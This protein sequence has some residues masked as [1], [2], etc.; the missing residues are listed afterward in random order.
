[1]R[2]P[3]WKAVVRVRAQLA[4]AVSVDPALRAVWLVGRWCEPPSRVSH[5]ELEREPRRTWRPAPGSIDDRPVRGPSSVLGPRRCRRPYGPARRSSLGLRLGLRATLWHVAA[6]RKTKVCAAKWPIS[7]HFVE[8]RDPDS[9][10]GHHDFQGVA[11]QRMWP[12]KTLQISRF[13]VARARRDAVGYARF[14]ACL[15]LRRG[16]EV[17]LAGQEPTARA[18]RRTRSKASRWLP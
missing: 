4:S 8:W 15:G 12:R 3:P 13:S 17:L 10:R 2:Q 18:A 7:R 9:N 16:L 5:L 6:K 11:A 14:G 1:M